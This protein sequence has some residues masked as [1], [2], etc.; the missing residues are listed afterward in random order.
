MHQG[1]VVIRISTSPAREAAPL[2][3]AITGRGI[4]EAIRIE[5]AARFGAVLVEFTGP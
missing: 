2:G 4:R 5:A 3:L 1:Y